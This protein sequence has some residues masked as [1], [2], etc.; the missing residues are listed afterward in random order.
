MKQ[1][2]IISE[3]DYWPQSRKS[4]IVINLF[5][6]IASA[7]FQS[8]LVFVIGL[9]F[10]LKAIG[11]GA[12]VKIYLDSGKIE[13]RQKLFFLILPIGKLEFKKEDFNKLVLSKFSATYS[14][15]GSFAGIPRS[16]GVNEVKL[17]FVRS[18]DQSFFSVPS[19]KLY[20]KTRKI[21]H[22]VAKEWGY[23]VDDLHQK[24]LA[25]N[26]EIRKRREATG[27]R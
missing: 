22:Q 11:Y 7:L 17:V 19:S 5:V 25:R 10:L 12:E 1:P 23:T 15:S 14:D 27:R 26:R 2:I 18:E 4:Q 9:V 13:K 20:N 6:I 16:T 21:A 3:R 24:E 8:T